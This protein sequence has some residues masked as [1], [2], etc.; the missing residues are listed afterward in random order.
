MVSGEAGMMRTSSED[1]NDVDGRVM[2][3]LK[4]Y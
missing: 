3:F 1:P 4:H 2:H